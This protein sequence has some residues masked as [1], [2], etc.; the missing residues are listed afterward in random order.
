MSKR[1][2]PPSAYLEANPHLAVRVRYVPSAQCF[3]AAII[4]RSPVGIT[5]AAEAQGSD[6]LQALLAA[7]DV[8]QGYE[9]TTTVGKATRARAACDQLLEAVG[10]D[11][12]GG[13]LLCCS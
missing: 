7:T 12:M 13:C 1:I 3:V 10:A 8:A 5:I 6:A 4:E 2:L 9:P 11:G